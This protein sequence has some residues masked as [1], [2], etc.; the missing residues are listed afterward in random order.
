VYTAIMLPLFSLSRVLYF[1]QF[2]G[3]DATTESKS[4]IKV[5]VA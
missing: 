5:F 3:K 2:K 4:H 1:S